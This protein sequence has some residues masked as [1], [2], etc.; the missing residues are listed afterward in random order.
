MMKTYRYAALIVMILLI[1][2]SSSFAQGPTAGTKPFIMPVAGPSSP[3]T[4]ILGQ[5]YGN[6]TGAYI[7]GADQYS[8]GQYLHFGVDIGMPCGTPVI[9]VADGIVDSVDNLYRGAAPHNLS[10]RF[11]DL[12]LSVLYGHLLERPALVEGQAVVQGDVVGLSGDPDGDCDLRPHLHFEVRSL[13]QST[14]YNPILFI[15]A[16]WHSL[17]GLDFTDQARFPTRS[18]QPTPLDEFRRSAGCGVRRAAAE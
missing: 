11:P 15:N 1:G 18:D 6:T 13:D 9:A 10:L 7:T 3:S 17:L 8:A 4:W 14:A 16:P 12:G 5:P 2:S